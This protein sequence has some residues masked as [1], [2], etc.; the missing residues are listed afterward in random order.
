MRDELVGVVSHDFRTPEGST[1]YVRSSAACRHAYPRSDSSRRPYVDTDVAPPPSTYSCSPFTHCSRQRSRRLTA[2]PVKT[3][4]RRDTD[5]PSDDL[6][7]KEPRTRATDC[8]QHSLQLADD[9]QQDH[10][11]YA[12]GCQNNGRI[13]P[14]PLSLHHKLRPNQQQQKQEL[15]NSLYIPAPHYA[16]KVLIPNRLSEDGEDQ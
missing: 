15:R 13:L 8:S 3:P 11:R 7:R 5:S 2:R 12:K 6:A 4:P 9:S 14:A 1:Q 16:P 10:I